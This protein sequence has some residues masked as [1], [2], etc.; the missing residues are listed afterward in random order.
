VY[1]AFVLGIGIPVMTSEFIIGRRT[2]RNPIGA[3]MK[4]APGKPWFLIGIM[5]VGAA[6]MI[7]AF[8]SAVAGWT[9]EY[10]YQS[11]LNNFVSKGP[12]ELT[13]FFNEFREE[14]WRPVIWFPVFMGLTAAIV[15]AG[16]KD[17]IEKYSKILMPALVIILIILC[18]RS[19][20]LSG[21]KQGWNSSSSLIFQRSPQVLLSRR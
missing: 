21:A 9:L 2:Q 8:Y 13:R 17:G 18:I 16:V 1:L 3:F 12:D 7:L 11:L 5:G 19:L 4:L 20:T 15:I 10:L 14:S 6:F